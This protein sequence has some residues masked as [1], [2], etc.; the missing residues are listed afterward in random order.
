[1]KLT[2][3]LFSPLAAVI[4]VKDEQYGPTFDQL[5]EPEKKFLA[6]DERLITY[7]RPHFQHSCELLDEAV[8][9]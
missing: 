4:D 5:S 9:I 7:I 3:A 6:V 8:L 2:S 1:M